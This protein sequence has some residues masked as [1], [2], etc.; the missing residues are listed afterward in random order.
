LALLDGPDFIRR[1]N[2]IR[3][4]TTPGFD[5]AVSWQGLAKDVAV[6]LV[7]LPALLFAMLGFGVV[8]DRT[9]A[10]EGG[11]WFRRWWTSAAS[12][13]KVRPKDG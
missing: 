2:D 9:S 1:F 7:A 5:H 6:E 8:F 13:P 3:T 10:L 12:K 11:P 4:T